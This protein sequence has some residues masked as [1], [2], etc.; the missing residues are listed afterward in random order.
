MTETQAHNFF[1][2]AINP[3]FLQN[4]HRTEFLQKVYKV[5]RQSWAHKLAFPQCRP[6]QNSS[7]SQTSTELLHS[8]T[9]SNDLSF[10]EYENIAPQIRQS[11]I[12][13]KF[14]FYNRY[15]EL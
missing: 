2:T 5:W 13:P 6:A 4:L 12:P 1:S 8:K 10:L 3:F 11:Q 7:S 9:V 14:S 15:R